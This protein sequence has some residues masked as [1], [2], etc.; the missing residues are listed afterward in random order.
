M[1]AAA[2]C[3]WGA[4][5]FFGSGM[6]F[7]AGA[8]LGAS[9]L[10]STEATIAK[11]DAML[12]GAIT[13]AMAALGRPLRRPRRGRAHGA[14]HPRP[15]L[16]RAQPVDPAQGP[17]RPADRRTGG[18]QLWAWDRHLRWLRGIGWWWGL[19]AILAVAG[20]W[21]LAVTIATDG[22]FWASSLGG[23]LAPKL[24]GGHETHGAPPACTPC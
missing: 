5:A 18:A 4:A 7:V 13:L 1:L 10:L 24:A 19:V 9:M 23:D 3:A 12:C 17:D 6:G 14:G 16:G 11:T 15:V 2:A 22:A 21:A 8:V 20:P